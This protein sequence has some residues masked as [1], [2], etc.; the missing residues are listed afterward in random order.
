MSVNWGQ[1]DEIAMYSS[2]RLPISL[3]CG[4]P[5]ITNYQPGYEHVFNNIPGLFIIKS[6][7][8]ALDVALYILNLTI[9]QRNELG[10]Q[11]AEYAIK[12]LEATVIYSNIVSV[13]TEQLFD[14]QATSAQSEQK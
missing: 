13:I 2:D 9:E 14:N 3:A 8:E 6:P 11:A 5:H 7:Q 4:V 12:H 10:F 1:Y